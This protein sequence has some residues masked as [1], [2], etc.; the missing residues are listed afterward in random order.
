MLQNLLQR[1][2]KF[3]QLLCTLA[4]LLANEMWRG[5]NIRGQVSSPDFSSHP[6]KHD[7]QLK[8]SQY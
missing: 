8:E 1:Y 6:G 2:S 4:P 5:G 7:H 3:A